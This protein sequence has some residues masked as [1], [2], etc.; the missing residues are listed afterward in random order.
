[1]EGLLEKAIRFNKSQLSDDKGDHG[2]FHV[3]RVRKLAGKIAEKEGGDRLIIDLAVL[4]HDTWDH[5]FHDG[6]PDKG[7]HEARKWL[8]QH[9][10]TPEVAEKVASI[11]GEVSFKGAKV[12][13]P[14]SSIESAIVQDADR[15]DAIGA[16]GIA[17]TFAYGG[18][19]GQPIYDP[20]IDPK[21]HQDFEAYRKDRTSTINHFYEKL[22]LL[23]DRMQTET[24]RKMAME[25]HQF[26][27][28]Y[29]ERFY[30]EWE[31]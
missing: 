29:L 12:A 25:R 28:E 4:F 26:M 20:D 31:G 3:S 10:A 1:M 30:Q 14:V 19:V 27:E 7:V 13:T 15:L 23:K 11:V 21:K 24:G 16:I 18:Y 9:G 2:W 22:L 17:R 6:T 5:K 8:K